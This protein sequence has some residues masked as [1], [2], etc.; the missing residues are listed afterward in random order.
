M[1]TVEVF[2]TN[3]PDTMVAGLLITR[4]QRLFPGS[5][6]NFDLEDCDKVLRVE[7]GDI[8]C[9][10]IINMLKDTGYDCGILI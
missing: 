7:G 8:C 3:V 2:K 9:E 4:L 10:Q 5:R 6:V 1:T